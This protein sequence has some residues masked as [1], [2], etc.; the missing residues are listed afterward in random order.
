MRRASWAKSNRGAWPTITKSAIVSR[1]L[2]RYAER[3]VFRAFSRTG[4]EFQ[5]RWLWDLRFHLTFDRKRGSLTFKKLLPNIPAGSDLETGLKDFLES[6]GS[7]ERPAHRRIDAA[8]L[9]VGFANRR[10]TVTLTFRIVGDNHEYAVK[11]A[12]G[13]VN[14]VF[15]GFLNLRYPEYMAENFRLPQE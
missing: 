11:K 6:F 12:L 2:E 13:I 3:G 7:P 4:D 5:F 9:S 1:E 10:G 15:L 14:E 8:R